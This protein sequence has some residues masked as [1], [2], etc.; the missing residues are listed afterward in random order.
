M[1]QNQIEAQ[2]T[3]DRSPLLNRTPKPPRPEKCNTIL[4]AESAACAT[5]NRIEKEK[6]IGLRRT[7][8][9][10]GAANDDAHSAKS[11]P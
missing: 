4:S 9:K 5:S 8:F 7:E 1:S 10:I 11:G 3:Q 2:S 6:L